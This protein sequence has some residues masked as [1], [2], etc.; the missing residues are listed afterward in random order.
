M[1]QQRNSLCANFC[2]CFV[3]QPHV[4]TIQKPFDLVIILAVLC[5]RLFLFSSLYFVMYSFVFSS[6]L[7]TFFYVL[8]VSSSCVILRGPQKSKTTETFP[9][10]IVYVCCNMGLL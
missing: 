8:D 2:S 7:K 9:E 5:F 4:F 3:S 1:K 10:V 6:A